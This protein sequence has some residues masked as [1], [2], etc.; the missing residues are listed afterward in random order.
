M[1]ILLGLAGACVAA[2]VNDPN[3]ILAGLGIGLVLD[4]LYALG[5]KL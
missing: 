4:A 3:A 1:T 5:V 2:I